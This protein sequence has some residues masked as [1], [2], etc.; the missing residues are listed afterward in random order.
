MTSAIVASELARYYD[1]LLA[2]DHV[3]FEVQQGEIFGYLGPNGAGKTTTI[4]M[5]TG[6]LRPSEG[7][8]YVRGHDI[9]HDLRKIKRSIGIVPEVSNVYDE[10]TAWDNLIFAAELYSVPRG[11]RETRA[12]ELLEEFDL[13]SDAIR[14]SGAFPE[15]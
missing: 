1:D 8:A 7:T 14:R 13:L 9:L 11:E 15:G 10:L 12:K 5:L 6:L 4:K 2:V 3:S